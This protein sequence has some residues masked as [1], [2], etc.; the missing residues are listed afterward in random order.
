MAGGAGIRANESG[1]GDAGRSHHDPRGG[2][3]HQ[4][5]GE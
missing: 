2:A 5:N 4:D 3:G 1:T